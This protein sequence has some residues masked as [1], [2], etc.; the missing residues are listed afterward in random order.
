MYFDASYHYMRIS[1]ANL[2]MFFKK[3]EFVCLNMIIFVLDQSAT[4]QQVITSVP[5]TSNSILL[6]LLFIS[7]FCYICFHS[8]KFD[9][10]DSV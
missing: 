5:N 2:E 7:L 9:I 3:I 4:T 6:T 10:C 1:S 8:A